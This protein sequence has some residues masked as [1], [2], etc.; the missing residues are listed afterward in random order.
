MKIT[1]SCHCGDIQYE[2]EVDPADV[3][4]CHCTDCQ[5]L[6]GSAFRT[7]AF[8][9]EHSFKLKKGE[10]TVYIKT[11]ADS[12][13]PREQTFCSVCGSP[14]YSRSP[15]RPMA[16]VAPPPGQPVPRL[17]LRVGT[18]AQRD[19]LK[20]RAQYYCSS[21][22]PWAAELID[23]PKVAGSAVSQPKK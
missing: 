21:A 7:V 4:A 5:S 23:A 20:P 17:G 9:A 14:L 1:G 10:P 11:T 3:V 22:L 8:A 12:G 15:G 13:N 6:S 2:A 18:I 19:V 16:R